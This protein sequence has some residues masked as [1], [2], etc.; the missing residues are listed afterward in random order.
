MRH[1]LAGEFGPG[2]ALATEA[3]QREAPAGE[4]SRAERPLETGRDLDAGRAG[5]KAV[6]V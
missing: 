2:P 4:D 5:E 3:P 1:H 6:P